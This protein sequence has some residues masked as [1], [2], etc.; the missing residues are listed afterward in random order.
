MF[1][2]KTAALAAVLAWAAIPSA[3]VAAE[4][5]A[6]VQAG[7]PARANGEVSVDIEGATPGLTPELFRTTLSS[8][9]DWRVSS[10]YGEVWRPRVALGWRPYYYG[11]WLWTDEGWYWDSS[12]PF[13]WA[14]YHYGRWVFDPVWGWVWIPGYQWAPAWVT[15][16]Y[17]DDVIGWAPLG[18]GVSVFV[19]AYPFID[20]WW[21]FVPCVDFVGVPVQRVAFP[22]RQSHRWFVATSPAPPRTGATLGGRRT[23]S[24]AW[25]GP[26]RS[27]VEQRTGRPIVT[28]YRAPTASPRLGEGAGRGRPEALGGRREGAPLWTPPGRSERARPEA[29]A[30]PRR[31][32]SR[33]QLRPMPRREEARPDVRPAP[34]R[35]G[36]RPEFQPPRREESRPQAQPAPRGEGSRS[37][38]WGGGG[39]ERG[40]RGGGRR[41]R[42]R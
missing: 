22:P 11:S 9:G 25:G 23:P 4:G 32:E 26:A 19:T 31:E 37:N 40:E 3:A 41:A 35:Q 21:T 5:E 18:P 33:P 36:G 7:A 42:E 2:I 34:R 1:R 12:E 8:F 13:A 10:R 39:G 17:A 29:G 24:P 27:F 20:F 6:E 28:Q 15:W 16:R 38:G 14:V 30:L